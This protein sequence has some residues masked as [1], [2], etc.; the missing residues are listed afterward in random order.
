MK[1]FLKRTAKTVAQQT[2]GRLPPP[3]ARL[4][5]KLAKDGA[6][7]VRNTRYRPWAGSPGGSLRAWADCVGPAFKDIF[8]SGVEG[9]PQTL[10]K[11]FAERWAKF[12]GCQHALMLALRMALVA[13]FAPPLDWKADFE[14]YAIM[15]V[16]CSK[17]DCY[18]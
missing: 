9:L 17:E 14:L 18:E 10:Q 16:K 6:T 3:A 13:M 8:L 15:A 11:E 12:C 5:G 2:I 1:A 7:P 4:A